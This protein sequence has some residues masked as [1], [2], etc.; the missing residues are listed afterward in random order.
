MDEIEKTWDVSKIL[1]TENTN[2]RYMAY[3]L[4]K[5]NIYAHAMHPIITSLEKSLYSQPHLVDVRAEAQNSVQKFILAEKQFKAYKVFKHGDHFYELEDSIGLIANTVKNVLHFFDEPKTFYIDCKH[6]AL[7]K[8]FYEMAT[9]IN[10]DDEVG[11]SFDFETYDYKL[12]VKS[13]DT[14]VEE[15]GPVYTGYSLFTILTGPDM[16]NAWNALC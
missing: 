12:L 6:A 8:Q 1:F 11:H 7:R 13:Y 9:R 3:L 5:H 10:A 2:P 15:D 14:Y 16:P 4:G